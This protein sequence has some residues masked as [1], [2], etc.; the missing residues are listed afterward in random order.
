MI[1]AKQLESVLLASAAVTA[2]T[3][4]TIATRGM[5]SIWRKRLL[6][7]ILWINLL[8]LVFLL[9]KTISERVKVEKSEY[10]LL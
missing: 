8:S 9:Q 3:G 4:L 7:Y 6:V 5:K 2:V 10:N 1:K